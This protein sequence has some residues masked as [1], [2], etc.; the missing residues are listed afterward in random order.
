MS[1]QVNELSE[2]I[3]SILSKGYTINIEATGY[4]CTTV[5]VSSAIAIERV[6]LPNDHINDEKLVKY[7]CLLT[8]AMDKKQKALHELHKLKWRAND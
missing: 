4:N 1:K 6:S 7:L 8:V 5:S 3:F 2:C